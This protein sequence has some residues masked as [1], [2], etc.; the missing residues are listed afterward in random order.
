MEVSQ[1]RQ[2]ANGSRVL[3]AFDNVSIAKAQET[4]SEVV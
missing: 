2:G 4:T 3:L 1:I